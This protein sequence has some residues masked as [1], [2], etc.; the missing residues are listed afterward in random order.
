MP[1]TSDAGL[2]CAHG[3]FAASRHTN[4]TK[5]R[6]GTPCEMCLHPKSDP[7]KNLISVSVRVRLF[8]TSSTKCTQLLMPLFVQ[9]CKILMM[10]VDEH[11]TQGLVARLYRLGRT[12]SE[13][14]NLCS[15]VEHWRDQPGAV[16]SLAAWLHILAKMRY[17]Y[18]SQSCAGFSEAMLGYILEY[19]ASSIHY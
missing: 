15:P 2:W 17:H 14:C 13:A 9:H 5:H 10:P 1:R 4:D 3:A 12:G 11:I 8:L 16:L 19:V 18:H 6:M 7:N